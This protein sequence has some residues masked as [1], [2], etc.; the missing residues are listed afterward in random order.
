MDISFLNYPKFFC[1]SCAKIQLSSH[2]GVDWEKTI[3]IMMQMIL[4]LLLWIPEEFF[5]R[6]KQHPSRDHNSFLFL[7]YHMGF[8]FHENKM[9]GVQKQFLIFFPRNVSNIEDWWYA[10]SHIVVFTSRR[11]CPRIF[12]SSEDT[13][14]H[15]VSS[16]LHL[17][18]ESIEYLLFL[19][20]RIVESLLF[21]LFYAKMV[22][23]NTFEI[24]WAHFPG[25]EKNP[26]HSWV[27][28]FQIPVTSGSTLETGWR[29]HAVVSGSAV[30]NKSWWANLVVLLHQRLF[31]WV[32]GSWTAAGF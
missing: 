21:F 26:S 22:V 15:F 24:V 18:R 11:G 20:Q 16:L 3:W 27:Y 31:Q 32:D 10:N 28:V 9:K 8:L 4:S 23:A 30:S 17:T 19:W 2:H 29:W 12:D 7:F 25:G 5:Q 6:L 14:V 1:F 13:N